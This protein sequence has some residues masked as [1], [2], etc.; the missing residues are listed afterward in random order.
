MQPLPLA[1]VFAFGKTSYPK[2]SRFATKPPILAFVL[3]L[4]FNSFDKP[5]GGLKFAPSNITAIQI[6]M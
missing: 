3:R 4:F 2:F 1:P 6:A 5:K